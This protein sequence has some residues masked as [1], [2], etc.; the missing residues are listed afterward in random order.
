MFLLQTAQMMLP[1]CTLIVATFLYF[2]SLACIMNVSVGQLVF[3]RA[4]AYCRKV[5]QHN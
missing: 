4:K 5:R 2:D 3:Y 1:F